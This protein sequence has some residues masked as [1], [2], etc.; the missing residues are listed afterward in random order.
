MHEIWIESQEAKFFIK[1]GNFPFFGPI[2]DET[3]DRDKIWFRYRSP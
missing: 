3:D 2:S 1:E